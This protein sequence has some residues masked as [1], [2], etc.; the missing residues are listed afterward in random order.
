MLKGMT[1]KVEPRIIDRGI[2]EP[3]Q[4]IMTPVN[5]DSLNLRPADA[6]SELSRSGIVLVLEQR[7]RMPSPFENVRLEIAKALKAVR[8]V[9]EPQPIRDDPRGYGPPPQELV[10]PQ[11]I[12]ARYLWF[13]SPSLDIA[14]PLRLSGSFFFDF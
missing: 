7:A 4:L 10:R 6:A 13:G 1:G 2:N 8:I 11:A 9:R 14:R 5:L 3:P 12:R